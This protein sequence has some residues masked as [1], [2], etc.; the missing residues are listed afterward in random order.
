ME[1]GLDIFD[2]Q[3]AP[4]P[5]SGYDDGVLTRGELDRPQ[6]GYPISDEEGRAEQL[7][8]YRE[9]GDAA[10]AEAAQEQVKPA[11]SLNLKI[12]FI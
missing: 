9:E 5:A 3:P 6:G 10:V 4:S 2:D 1:D 11:L 8:V 12:A 7:R